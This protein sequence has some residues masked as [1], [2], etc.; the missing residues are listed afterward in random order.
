MN[1]VPLF[2]LSTEVKIPFL[3]P[4]DQKIPWTAVVASGAAKVLQEHP[5]A[6]AYFVGKFLKYII[7]YQNIAI[8]F[9]VDRTINNVRVVLSAV[10]PEA[11]KMTVK[12]IEEFLYR[13]KNDDILDVPEFTGAIRLQKAPFYIGKMAFALAARNARARQKILG[14]VAVST[15]GHAPIKNFFGYG[16][17]ALT[18]GV[19]QAYKISDLSAGDCY[20]YVLPLSLT[21][22]H[23]VID[24]AEAAAIMTDM[25]DAIRSILNLSE[26]S[27]AF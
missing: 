15:L 11:E 2:Y 26:V 18:F 16:G 17:T 3:Q 7:R 10:M 4:Y 5:G 19:G 21:V 12:E 27:S 6:N 20:C 1:N 13:I 8:K 22:D 14:T 9:T 23:R 25:H 24:G